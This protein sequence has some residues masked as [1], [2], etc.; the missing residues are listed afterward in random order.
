MPA[1]AVWELR[2]RGS[3]L[4]SL[5]AHPK[6]RSSRA[7]RQ[8]HQSGDRRPSSTWARIWSMGRSACSAG[9][10]RADHDGYGAEDLVQ[11]QHLIACGKAV[12]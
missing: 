2:R 7:I 9:G 5:A 8:G 4:A 12:L 1:G 10:L 11:P 3:S 6:Q